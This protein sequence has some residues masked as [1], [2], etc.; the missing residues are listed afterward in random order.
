MFKIEDY[1]Y[2]TSSI[3]NAYFSGV[4]FDQ[5]WDCITVASNREELDVA[6]VITIAL[7]DLRKEQH[8]WYK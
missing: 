7:N 3:G 6:I 8:D 5:L 4:S 1:E 2:I